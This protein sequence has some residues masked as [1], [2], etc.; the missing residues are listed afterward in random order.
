MGRYLAHAEVIFEYRSS[1]AAGPANQRNEYR[2]GFLAYYDKL[3][4]T[5]N[6]RNDLQHFQD[7]HRRS[8]S[9]GIQPV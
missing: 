7:C 5:I 6:L 2:Q 8:D 1:E 4:E 3:W 9:V